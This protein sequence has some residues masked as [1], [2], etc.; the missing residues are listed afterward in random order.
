MSKALP[1]L[2]NTPPGGWRY[3]VPETQKT[4]GPFS[5]WIQLQEQLHG[6]YHAAGY[7]VPANLFDLVQVQI[8]NAQPEYCG[9]IIVQGPL[10]SAIQ[11]TKHTFHAGLQCL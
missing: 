1:N 3:A 9:D 8:C 10:S 4:L 7:P 2:T 11:A 5:G 6:H